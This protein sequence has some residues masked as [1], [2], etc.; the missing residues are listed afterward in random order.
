MSTNEFVQDE[1]PSGTVEFRAAA[2]DGVDF[3]DRIMTLIAVPYDDPT[4]VEFRG[5][6]WMESF[7][8]TAFNGLQTRQ[9][10]I[11][12]VADMEIKDQSHVGAKLVGRIIESDPSYH[13]GLLVRAHISKTRTGDEALALANDGSLFPSVGVAMRSDGQLLDHRSKTR[14]INK[15]FLDHVALVPQPAYLGAKVLEVRSQSDIEV[16]Q[17]PNLD[18]YLDDPIHEWARK[19][20]SNND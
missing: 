1:Y 3:T 17:T 14:R 18:D 10:A 7:A 9:R 8:N 13:A 4:P 15:A 5:Q 6:R 16:V 11:P 19:R 12:V 20:L 2:L